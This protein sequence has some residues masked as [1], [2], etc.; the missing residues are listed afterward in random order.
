[1]TNATPLTTISN[2]Q[3][4]DMLMS[5][6]TATSNLELLRAANKLRSGA[7]MFYRY[8]QNMPDGAS[9][10]IRFLPASK[11]DASDVQS[12]F[13]CQNKK[14]RLRFDDPLAPDTQVVLQIPVMMSYIPGLRAES[15][16]I[17]RQVKV[18]YDI[19]AKAKKA[20][21]EEE[22]KRMQAKAN[23]HWPRGDALAQG[24]VIKSPFVENDLPE[25][26]IRLFELSKQIMNV[27]NEVLQTE[28]P[29]VGLQYWP[30]HGKLGTNFVIKKTRSGEWPKYDAGSGF[31]RATTPLSTEQL[32]ALDKYGLWDL[33]DFLPPRPTDAEYAAAAEIVKASIAGEQTWDSDWEQHFDTIKCYRVTNGDNGTVTGEVRTEARAVLQDLGVVSVADAGASDDVTDVTEELRTQPPKSTQDTRDMVSRIR[34]RSTH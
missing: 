18:L 29:A 5:D 22:Y 25:N 24:F 30:V 2:S 10:T 15:D 20:G 13:W 31:A 23:F 6:E 27:I 33:A 34:N 11:S 1:M 17:L 12:K 8:K 14:I 4:L 7:N 21:R 19:A 16:I 3:F 26:P 28:D 32:A 9:A